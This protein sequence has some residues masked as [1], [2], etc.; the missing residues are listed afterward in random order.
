MSLFELEKTR[1]MPSSSDVLESTEVPRSIVRLELPEVMSGVR[2]GMHTDTI[3][4]LLRTLTD[5]PEA[6]DLLF[7]SRV[8]SP[9]QRRELDR[10][11]SYR[12]YMSGRVVR[13]GNDLGIVLEAGFNPASEDVS[14]WASSPFSPSTLSRRI[15]YKV[16]YI[17]LN[18]RM[19]GDPSD[20]YMLRGAIGGCN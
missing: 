2:L 15:G 17:D 9:S 20:Q 19:P 14:R 4:N 6:P 5:I 18:G 3:G 7:E 8:L 10:N 16:S 11:R 1:Q 13:S 12:F